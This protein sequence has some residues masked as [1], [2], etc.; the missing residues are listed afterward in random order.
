[1]PKFKK[2]FLLFLIASIFFPNLVHSE[3]RRDLNVTAT[4]P[5]DPSDFSVQMEQ[6]TSGDNFP[7]G[8]NIEYEITYGSELNTPVNFTLET[9]WYEGETEDQSTTVSV[10][11]YL[12]GSATDA[13][14]G[15]S[16]VIDTVNKKITWGITN[17]PPNASQ[18]VRFKLRTNTNYQG[19]Q[20]VTFK[21]AGRIDGPGFITP[22]SNVFSTYLYSAPPTPTPSPTASIPSPGPTSSPTPT[23]AP[24]NPEFQSIQIRTI[25]DDS[26]QIYIQTLPATKSVIKYGTSLKSLTK[27]VSSSTFTTDQFITLTGLSPKTVYYFQVTSTTP[28]GKQITSDVYT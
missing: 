6:L 19:S 1:M 5:A 9:Q 28:A 15:A 25:S 24:S 26:A 7:Q 3:E 10:V 27:S 16:P 13:Y 4:V 2:L 11:D 18:T 12:S 23:T 20:I 22:D 14:G 8:T 17:F 21:V